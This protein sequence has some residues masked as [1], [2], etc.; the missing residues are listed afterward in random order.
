MN[1]FVTLIY[2]WYKLN[3]RN[4]PWRDDKDPYKIWLS[5][6]ILQQTRVEQGT[7]YFTRFIATY[8]SIKHLAN[9]AEDEVLKLWQGLGYYSRARNLHATA[10]IISSL[11][12]GV[13]P[14]DYKT[15]LSLKGVGPYTAAAIASIAFNLPYPAVDGNIYRVLARYFGITT[16]IDSVQGKKEFQQLAE[17]L[18]TEHDPGMH[19]QAF[20]EFGALQCV[21]KSPNCTICP[22][23]NSCHA[24]INNSISRLPVKE[25]KTKQRKRFFY[26]YIYDEGDSII[27]DKRTGQDIWQNLYQL[28]LLETT[29]RLSDEALLKSQLPVSTASY[30]IKYISTEKKH[31]LSHQIIYSKTI[32]IEVMCNVNI[33]SPLIRVNKKD[34][35]KFAVPRLVEQF[36]NDAGLGD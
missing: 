4:L 22:L 7:G 25:K 32:Y 17:E 23:N 27:M 1:D 3:K 14:N 36:L 8:P 33:P 31:V 12:D 13:F 19:N 26:Y 6:I 5:E 28:P 15:I 24:Y 29:N 11:Y 9:A 2:K 30:N 16:P 34:I 10:K 35:S 21:P 18:L 20:M